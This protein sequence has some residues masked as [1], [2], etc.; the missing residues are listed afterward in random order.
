MSKKDKILKECDGL[1]YEFVLNK[2]GTLIKKCC[3]SCKFK[4]AYDTEG[5]RR[6][7][8]I[9]PNVKDRIVDKK[10]VC[11]EWE[12]SDDIDKIKTLA[13]RPDLIKK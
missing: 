4:D 10:H 7:C 2:K 5:P 13:S 6:L 9:D 12:I 3:A 11:R 1:F 8:R